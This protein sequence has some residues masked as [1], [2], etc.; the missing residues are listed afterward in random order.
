MNLTG[1]G[2]LNIYPTY[3]E[4]FYLK[5]WIALHVGNIFLRSAWHKVWN[6]VRPA[7]GDGYMKPDFGR[8]AFRKTRIRPIVPMPTKIRFAFW[9]RFMER[10][11][12]LE[13]IVKRV[14]LLRK[15][16]ASLNFSPA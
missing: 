16:S 5:Q 8:T 14:A 6:L 9:K 15:L 12:G 7:Q 3:P 13:A 10:Q 11:R 4:I 2:Q 1:E